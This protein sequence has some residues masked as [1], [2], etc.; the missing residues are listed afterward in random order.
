MLGAPGKVVA[1]P[2]TAALHSAVAVY[3]TMGAQVLAA[4]HKNAEQVH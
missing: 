2:V 4:Q 3:H 1:Q